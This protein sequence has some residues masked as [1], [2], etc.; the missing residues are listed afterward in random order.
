MEALLQREGVSGVAQRLVRNPQSWLATYRGI[1]Q[2][3]QFA[4][5]YKLLSSIE[6]SAKRPLVYREGVPTERLNSGWLAAQMEDPLAGWRLREK[7][8]GEVRYSLG[9]QGC[10]PQHIH[11]WKLRTLMQKLHVSAS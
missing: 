10:V 11:T 7:S 2:E 9:L 4:R 8:R 5:L 3:Q 1:P 6:A